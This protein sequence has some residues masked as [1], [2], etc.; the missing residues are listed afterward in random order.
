METGSGACLDLNSPDSQ[1]FQPPERTGLW[2]AFTRLIVD[3][4]ECAK[5]CG[6]GSTVQNSHQWMLIWSIS[7]QKN[8]LIWNQAQNFF[9]ASFN[10]L[11]L[12]DHHHDLLPVTGLKLVMNHLL[13]CKE[14]WVCLLTSASPRCFLLLGWSS[15]RRDRDK[16]A[17][18][19]HRSDTLIIKDRDVGLKHPHILPFPVRTARFDSS[20]T[21]ML[22]DEQVGWMFHRVCMKE[23]STWVH[24]LEMER[25]C[26]AHTSHMHHDLIQP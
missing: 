2:C 20:P 3:N 8:N 22:L 4:P 11:I 9:D 17:S 23:A 13:P 24:P 19:V 21:A 1:R 7:K 16:D 10:R 15:S 12:S 5:R 26:K 18:R 25:C 6:M 14:C